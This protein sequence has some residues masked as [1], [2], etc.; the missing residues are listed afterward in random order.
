MTELNPYR[1]SNLYVSAMK[2]VDGKTDEQGNTEMLAQPVDDQEGEEFGIFQ[3]DNEQC[4][5]AFKSRAEAEDYFDLIA[6]ETEAEQL[7]REAA[8]KRRAF[9]IRHGEVQDIARRAAEVASR[10]VM[11]AHKVEL[12]AMQSAALAAERTH[13]DH[14]SATAAHPLEGRT[15]AR[16]INRGRYSWN[17]KQVTERGRL[18][19]RRNDT[20][21]A[22][23]VWS[24][25]HDLPDL[26]G[27]FIRRLKADGSVGSQVIKVYRVNDDGT[28]HCG[29]LTQGHG[30]KL[31]ESA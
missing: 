10:A 20:E 4:V 9:Q 23:S 6:V 2:W 1:R 16:T 22:D 12:D 21:F 5:E 17:S 29:G 24:R 18:E 25:R 31:E 3:R 30:W 8:E 11:D 26:G 28:F 7:E 13:R 15:V 14:V 19:V 27:L